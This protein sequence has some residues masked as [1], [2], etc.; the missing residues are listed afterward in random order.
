MK[1]IIGC[2]PSS[3]SSL[4]CQILNR[5]P[6]IFCGPETNLFIQPELYV[7]WDKSK[8][9]LNT[10][11]PA[12][13][14]GFKKVQFYYQAKIKIDESVFSSGN[15][16]LYKYHSLEKFA[17]V[18]FNFQ[19]RKVN[20]HHWVEKTP[21]NALCFPYLIKYFNTI[22]LAT[23]VRNPLDTIYSLIRRGQSYYRAVSS[24]LLFTSHALSVQGINFI[25][26][27]S[28]VD[29]P[30]ETMN[31]FL[32]NYN[33]TFHEEMLK[34]EPENME[35]IKMQ[36]W[37]HAE[38]D[39]IKKG[40]VNKFYEALPAVQDE[41]LHCIATFKI[42]DSY[43]EKNRLKYTTIPE[44]ALSLDYEIPRSNYKLSHVKFILY[45]RKEQVA[46]LWGR[47]INFILDYGYSYPITIDL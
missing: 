15:M 6:E 36:G 24:Y 8:D 47:R 41:I 30:V 2:S 43:A 4:L 40:A 3:G 37:T 42:H 14:N 19:A 9:R 31:S 18:Y 21:A 13:I 45:R 17:E 33:I 12:F 34:V 11:L 27:E 26:Y 39:A 1:L 5:H 32:K 46:Y 38:N 22:E 20:K 28:L 16:N 44:I 35:K 10:T 23:I 29:S 7:K 25:R